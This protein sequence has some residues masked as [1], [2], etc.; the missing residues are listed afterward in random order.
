MPV[1]NSGQN[2][3]VPVGSLA[4][5]AGIVAL[6]IGCSTGSAVQAGGSVSAK[7]AIT[8]LATPAERT[9]VRVAVIQDKTLSTGETRT[10]Q[11]KLEDMDP[12]VEL[13]G[14]TGGELAVGVIHDRSNLTFARLRIDAAPVEPVAPVEADNPLERRKQ[15]A[16]FRKQ[17]EKFTA[18]EQDWQDRMQTRIG[19]FQDAVDPILA[20]AADAKR[21]PVWDAVKRAD[22]FLSESESDVNMEAHRYALLITDGLDDVGARSV[23]VH[24]GTRILIVNGAGQLGALAVLKPQRFESIEAAIRY[25]VGLETK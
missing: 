2:R 10:P 4:M 25:I 3:S 8:T 19:G 6:Q 1:I 9:P 15:H 23:P 5:L 12:L 7:D 22:L 14:Q 18:D 20:M 13:L 24:S 21:S 17:K 16:A 11:L